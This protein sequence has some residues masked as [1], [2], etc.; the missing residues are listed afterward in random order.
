MFCFTMIRELL[1]ILGQLHFGNLEEEK[2]NGTV[3]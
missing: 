2:E 1:Y 3:N